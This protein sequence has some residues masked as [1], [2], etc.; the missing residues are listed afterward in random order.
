MSRVWISREEEELT[1][2]VIICCGLKPPDCGWAYVLAWET[3][4]YQISLAWEMTLV[5][6]G[7]GKPVWLVEKLPSGWW[8][9]LEISYA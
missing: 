9:D 8:L 1:V 5:V 2:S 7:T 6:M 3:P 4:A